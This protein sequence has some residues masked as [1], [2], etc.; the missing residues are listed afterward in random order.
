MFRLE[1][2]NQKVMRAREISFSSQKV[3]GYRYP[4][5]VAMPMVTLGMADR[6]SRNMNQNTSQPQFHP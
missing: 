6:Y 5:M 1:K 3:R 2:M 4:I